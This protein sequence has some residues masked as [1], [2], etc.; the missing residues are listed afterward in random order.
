MKQSKIFQFCSFVIGDELYGINI[1]EVKEIKD[2]FKC[3]PVYHAPKGIK[4]FVNIR[5]QVY[6]VLDLQ[7]LLKNKKNKNLKTGHLILFKNKPG[8]DHFGIYVDKHSGV[9]ETDERSIE[10]Q[11]QDNKNL[12]S[13]QNRQHLVIG[14]CKLQEKLMTILNIDNLLNAVNT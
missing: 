13:V 9:V 4:G 5:G 14:V 6:L 11:Q 7:I 8:R 12:I 3:T 10:Y 1:N 2:E